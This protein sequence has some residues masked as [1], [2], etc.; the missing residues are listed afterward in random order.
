MKFKRIDFWFIALI[1]L[2]VALVV[3]LDTVSDIKDTEISELKEQIE[4]MNLEYNRLEDKY[5]YLNIDAGR[6]YKIDEY[7][8]CTLKDDNHYHRNFFFCFLYPDEPKDV[9][10]GAYLISEAKELGY[11][12]CP[13]CYGE[14]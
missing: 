2:S 9:I 11:A 4:E 3:L 6:L 13:I 8:C 5:S 14:D 7:F 10:T 12:P 1:V